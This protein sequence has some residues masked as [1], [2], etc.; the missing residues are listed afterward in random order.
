MGMENF[1]TLF[2]FLIGLANHV[3]ARTSAQDVYCAACESTITEIERILMKPSK[4]NIAESV[5]E[6]V[7][8]VCKEKTFKPYFEDAKDDSK[9]QDLVKGCKHLLDQHGGHIEVLFRESYSEQRKT[10]LTLK[11][12]FIRICE[13]I[14]KACPTKPAEEKEQ[15]LDVEKMV[16]QIQELLKVEKVKLVNPVA[17]NEEL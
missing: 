10:K 17:H 14:S 9:L 13:Q 2:I 6:T 12:L 7:A 8:S 1:L 5:H 15:E 3:F 4:K 16:D 11:E